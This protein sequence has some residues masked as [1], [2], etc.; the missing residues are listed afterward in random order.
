VK[1]CAPNEALE[2]DLIDV[3]Q[4]GEWQVAEVVANIGASIWILV[5]SDYASSEHKDSCREWIDVNSR[6][7][8]VYR[9]RAP[10]YKPNHKERVLVPGRSLIVPDLDD[11][12]C[13]IL[14]RFGYYA[15]LELPQTDPSTNPPRL[16]TIHLS[17]L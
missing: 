17:H 7:L 3:H 8:D 10:K 13:T 6:R 16:V 4:N 5:V 14:R 2:R 1:R 12:R 15:V 11:Q 9:S